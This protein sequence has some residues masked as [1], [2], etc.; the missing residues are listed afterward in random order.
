VA[1]ARTRPLV[2]NA[3]NV[4]PGQRAEVHAALVNASVHAFRIGMLISSALALLGGLVSLIGIEN[5][6]RRVASEDC[7]G[8]ALGLSAEAAGVHLAPAGSRN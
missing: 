1:I 7:Q 3:Q 8:G 6:R 4:P 5:P 2:T